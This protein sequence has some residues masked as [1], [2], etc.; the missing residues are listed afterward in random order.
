[1]KIDY[2]VEADSATEHL[3]YLLLKDKMSWKQNLM[4]YQ[5]VGVFCGKTESNT[6][7]VSLTYNKIGDKIICFYWGTSQIVNHKEIEEYLKKGYKGVPMLEA[8]TFVYKML[9]GKV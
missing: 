9:K 5:N 7:M 6:N 1:M 3:I 4:G 8:D 2:L